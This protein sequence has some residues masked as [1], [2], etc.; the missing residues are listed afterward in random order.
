MSDKKQLR[1]GLVGTGLMGRAHANGYNRIH[2]FFPPLQYE[3]RLVAVCSRN[4]EKVKAF[5][6]QWNFE[7]YETDWKALVAR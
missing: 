5:A 1:I 2:N 6:A 7:S 3:P 4:E